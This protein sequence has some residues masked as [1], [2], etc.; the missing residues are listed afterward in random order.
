MEHI[1]YERPLEVRFFETDWTGLVR[2]AVVFGYLQEA[3]VGHAL[4]RRITLKEM[5]QQNLFWVVSRVHLCMD[6]YPRAGE[7]VTM[8]T[9]SSTRQEIFTCRE[10]EMLDAA[11]GVLARATSSW[12]L[13]S[14]ETRRPVPLDG[15]LPE[16][17]IDPRR[18]VEDDFASLPELGAEAE[19]T[20]RYDVL[21]RDLDMNGHVN[22]SV[23]VDWALESLPQQLARNARVAELEI[24]FR[25]EAHYGEEIVARCAGTGSGTAPDSYIHQV[26]SAADDR[27]LARL[28]TRWLPV[29]SF[30]R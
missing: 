7:T 23:Y 8:R 28:R 9:W 25:A 17:A 30:T 2:P 5:R 22:N 12:A 10:F 21:R 18:A 6:R 20:R 15:N 3:V 16:F 13:L 4:L 29:E 14:L 27:E 24:G 26:R 19:H 11:G 1:H